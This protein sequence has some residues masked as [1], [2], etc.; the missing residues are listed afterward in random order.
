M[1]DSNTGG[2]KD[3]LLIVL[4]LHCAATL[5]HFA[6][7]AVY[8]N[9]YPNLPGWITPGGVVYSW[10]VVTA[11]G[12]AGYLVYRLVMRL[13]GLLVLAVYGVLGFDGLAHYTLAPLS[14]HTT[15]MNLSIGLEAFTAVLVLVAVA[16]RLGDY[17][18]GRAGLSGPA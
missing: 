8:I 6:H 12:A 4:A 18:P 3:D 7:N 17:L 10:L 15:A 5:F 14:A 11:I 13:P 1:S 9:D 16:A 2:R